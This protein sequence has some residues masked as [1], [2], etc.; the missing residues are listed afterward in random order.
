MK[1]INGIY[2]YTNINDSKFDV[3]RIYVPLYN[4]RSLC[5]LKN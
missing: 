5:F 2:K 3:K 4:V 1:D